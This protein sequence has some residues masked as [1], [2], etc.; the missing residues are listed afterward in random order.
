[1]GDVGVDGSDD[2]RSV[3][4][5]EDG[6]GCSCLASLQAVLVRLF[7]FLRPF[8]GQSRQ[9]LVSTVARQMREIGMAVLLDIRV[10][11]LLW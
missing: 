8:R 10:C 7:P 3:G 5:D 1:M 9:F 6:W 4:C 11:S 2:G